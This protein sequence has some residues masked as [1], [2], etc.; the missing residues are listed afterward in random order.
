[1]AC[2]YQPYTEKEY[3]VNV[4]NTGNSNLAQRGSQLN[5]MLCHIT[6]ITI[7][8]INIQS[9]NI[10]IFLKKQLVNFF[11]FRLILNSIVLQISVCGL[12]VNS[13]SLHI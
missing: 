11:K 10:Y 12:F 13:L 2:P 6:F 8:I 4:L 5:S 3:K 7:D 9:Q 1:M